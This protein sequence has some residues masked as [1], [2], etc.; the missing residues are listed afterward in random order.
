MNKLLIILTAL[1]GGTVPVFSQLPNTEIIQPVMNAQMSGFEAVEVM[2][3][4]FE[5][6]KYDDFLKEMDISYQ[7]VKEQGHLNQL[8]EMRVGESSQ[9][10]EFEEKALVLQSE[11]SKELISAVEDQTE[12]LFVT[13]VLSAAADLSDQSHQDAI[14]RIASFRAM[15]PGMGKN[16]D[17][18]RLIDLDLEYEY[19]SL[20]LDLPG[21]SV[22]EKREKHCA[23]KMEKLQKMLDASSD[24]QDESLKEAVLIYASNFDDRLAQSWDI[25]DLNALTQGTV[26][27]QNA[28]EE[29]VA[30]ILHSYQEKFSDMT[31]QFITEH[32]D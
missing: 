5:K 24:F 16:V 7:S 20:H 21:S 8:A 15:S 28:L 13:K 18:N 9:L 17:E 4:S 11:K 32:E 6:G 31:R 10:R 3:K 12:S 30:Q 19:K 29:K 22:H 2:R 14:A 23:L 27:P 25:A 26:K 1:T